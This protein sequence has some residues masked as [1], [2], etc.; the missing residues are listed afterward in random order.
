LDYTLIRTSRKTLAIYIR[1]GG[2][3][4]VRAPIGMPSRE[5][6]RFITQK[7]KWI[8]EKQALVL[9]RKEQPPNPALEA[10]CRA[11]AKE[12][13]PG[14]VAKYAKLL[15]VAPAR[16][17]ISGA[18]T[19]WGSCSGGGNL[20]FSWRLFLAGDATIDYVVV[21]ELAHLLE[22]NHGPR[23]WAIVEGVLPAYAAARAELKRLQRKFNEFNEENWED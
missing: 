21:H 15:G 8:T 4:E 1:P 23:F 12:I 18:K 3:V 17:K 5:I 16:V 19:R 20:N 10:E 13:L 11:L 22:M 6:E 2:L 7:E 14:K 9:S